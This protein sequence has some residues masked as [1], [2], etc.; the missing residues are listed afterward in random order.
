MSNL[1]TLPVKH[2]TGHFFDMH[3]SN[4]VEIDGEIISKI[5]NVM[6]AWGQDIINT[7]IYINE[8]HENKVAVDASWTI[9]LDR[10]HLDRL[11]S[12]GRENTVLNSEAFEEGQDDWLQVRP[13]HVETIVKRIKSAV[14]SALDVGEDEGEVDR[15]CEDVP[16]SVFATFT[17]TPDAT[18]GDMEDV[19]RPFF[20][21]MEKTTAP[22]AP[23]Q[24]YIFGQVVLGE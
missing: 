22:D 17:V 11:K 5:P 8:I 1:N 2:F 15:W 16:F 7:N 14:P 10:A 18:I 24:D 19:V 13:E 9:T 12:E 21:F 20:E 23:D 4:P 6:G 3:D